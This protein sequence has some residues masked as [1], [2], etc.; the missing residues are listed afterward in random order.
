MLSYHLNNLQSSQR[1]AF[2]PDAKRKADLTTKD[3]KSTK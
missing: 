1:I 3:T 2:Y